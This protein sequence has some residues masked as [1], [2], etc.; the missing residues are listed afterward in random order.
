MRSAG[1]AA[2][3]IA[4]GGTTEPT[5]GTDAGAGDGASTDAARTS[6]SAWYTR[7][8][9]CYDDANPPLVGESPPESCGKCGVGLGNC[10]P[11]EGYNEGTC[12]SVSGWCCG[13]TVYNANQSHPTECLCGNEA[14][15]VLGCVEPQVCCALPGQQDRACVEAAA[16]R[17]AGGGW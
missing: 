16:C 1:L 3:L 14:R 5:D 17:D 11:F 7:F 10:W 4:C 9:A 2:I 13:G 12:D 8:D 6:D 15:G